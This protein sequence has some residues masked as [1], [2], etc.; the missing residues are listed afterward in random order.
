MRLRFVLL[1]MLAVVSG[2]AGQQH[3]L[4]AAKGAAAPAANIARDHQ[5]Y[6]ATTRAKARDPR[7]VFSGKRSRVTTYAMVDVS[8][9]ATHKP[10]RIERPVGDVADPA[11]YFTARNLSIYRDGGAFETALGADIKARGGNALVFI[12]GY[13]THFDDAVYRIT[14]IAQDSGYNGAAVLFT[15]ASAGQTVDYVYDTNSATAARD[16]LEETLR[17]VAKSGAKR[18]DIIAHSLGNWATMEALRQL[19]I[20]KDRDLSG[21]LGD[22]V[23]ASPDLDVD[24]F[25]T[26]MERYGK[27][28]HPFLV[29]ASSQDRA[30]DISSWVAGDKPR[31]GD[32][33]NAKD[34]VDYGVIVVDLSKVRAGDQFDHTTFADNANVIKLLGQGLNEED[35]RALGS[36]ASV[37][38]KVNRFARGL[39]QTLGSAADIVITTPLEVLTLGAAR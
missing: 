19:A 21:K 15:W 23:L 14:Q 11:R 8:V 10:G 16:A 31:L 39:G 9:P 5:I 4:L 35:A 24:V 33:L 6:I 36:D 32:Y 12:H 20:T 26:Q 22:V 3:E 18:I 17:L 1:T 29:L 28:K 7:E 27:P 37:T 34:I 2:C 13:N 30:L 25:K 38:A